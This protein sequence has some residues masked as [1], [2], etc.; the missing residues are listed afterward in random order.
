M[1]IST[2][3]RTL[4]TIA[5]ATRSSPP[6]PMPAALSVDKDDPVRNMQVVGSDSTIAV[7]FA[8]ASCPTDGLSNDGASHGPATG[9][10]FSSNIMPDAGASQHILG[11]SQFLAEVSQPVASHL[12]EMGHF[13][14]LSSDRE[15]VGCQPANAVLSGSS[16]QTATVAP[17]RHAPGTAV[18]DPASTMNT[19]TFVVA[20]PAGQGDASSSAVDSVPHVV[21]GSNTLHPDVARPATTHDDLGQL[22]AHITRDVH[23]VRV[24]DDVGGSVPVASIL[25]GG[26]ISDDGNINPP[27]AAR[28]FF[29]STASAPAVDAPLTRVLTTAPPSY[30]PFIAAQPLPDVTPSQDYTIAD[31]FPSDTAGQIGTTVLID[32][33]GDLTFWR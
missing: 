12:D 18:I 19:G 7:G 8:A 32:L 1:P 20:T 23:V 5:P 27:F 11:L 14:L 21:N 6:P 17:Q 3:S 2:Q 4:T 9:N 25:G 31:A 16:Q 15:G 28:P 24:A 26:S 22:A 13:V 10:K 29:Q 30:N 33:P